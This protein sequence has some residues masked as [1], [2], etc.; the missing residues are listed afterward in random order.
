MWAI[1]MGMIVEVREVQVDRTSPRAAKTKRVIVYRCDQCDCVYEGKYTEKFLSNR[2]FQLCSSMCLGLSR[3]LG[4]IAC[5]YQLAQRDMQSWQANMQATVLEKYGVTN[6]SMLDDI[7]RKKVQ[8]FQVRYGVDNPQQIPEVKQRTIETHAS[9]GRNWMSKPE[10][11]FRIV[12]E[13]W[14]GKD[15][16]RVQILLEKRWSVDFYLKS[17]DTY[18]QFDGVYW[19]GLDR[20]LD[21]I[22]SS[23][24]KRDQAIHGK[25]IKDRE[26]DAYVAQ[27]GLRLV[28]V[29]DVEFKTDPRACLLK[30]AGIHGTPLHHST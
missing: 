21:E 28:R 5:D 25:W 15:D 19:H 18:V 14:L 27:M 12:L 13:D 22:R 29:T 1:S 7:K 24:M 11:E 16:V 26:L 10:K 17:L 3:K 2:R 4:G 23:N 8:T 20:S 9:H 6:V 30:I